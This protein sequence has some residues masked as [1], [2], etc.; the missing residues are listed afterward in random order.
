[1]P[2]INELLMDALEYLYGL[3]NEWGWKVDSIPRFIDEYEE[4]E[5]T[6]KKV[7]KYL[8]AKHSESPAQEP[9]KE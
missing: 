2:D 9:E 3:K 5:I 8:D 6:I 7:E 1:M 4:L